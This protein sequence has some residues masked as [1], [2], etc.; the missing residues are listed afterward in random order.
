MAKLVLS[1]PQYDL[2][3]HLKKHGPSWRGAFRTD[4][5]IAL[6]RKGLIEEDGDNLRVTQ[7]GKDYH[8]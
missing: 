8:G 6:K 5:A 1:T 3:Q 7:A 4:V 2:L